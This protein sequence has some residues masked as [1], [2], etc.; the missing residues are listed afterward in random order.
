MA[1]LGDGETEYDLAN[2]GKENSIAACSVREIYMIL[3]VAYS[4]IG[5]SSANRHYHQAQANP[6][7]K[8]LFPGTSTV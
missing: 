1:M 5:Q 3:C 2:D 8:R 4:C 6:L 7:P